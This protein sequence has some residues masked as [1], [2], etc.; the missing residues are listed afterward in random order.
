MTHNDHIH[1]IKEA[2]TLDEAFEVVEDYGQKRG[3]P[4]YMF[5]QI[6][7]HDSPSIFK[8]N[9]VQTN[10][11]DEWV[12]SYKENLYFYID[13]VAKAMVNN[14]MPFF[15]SEHIQ[16]NQDALNDDV[17]TMMAHA[18]Q[19]GLVD[20]TGSSYLKNKGNLCT[21]SMAMDK[22]FESYDHQ[23]LAEVYLIGASL[24][25]V[26][27]R[28]FTK[29]DAYEPLTDRE[30]E[31]IN[32]G[33]VGKTDGEIAQICDISINTVRYHWKNIF[34]KLQSFSR[35]F[36]IVRAMN[37]GYI[38]PYIFEMTTESGSIERYKKNVS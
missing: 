1:A 20:G 29:Y 21:F 32:M 4:L 3:L 23:L 8:V 15:W 31:I 2:N 26:H 6:G 11:P 9:F 7:T 12:N 28:F 16:K 35:V 19:Y 18:T 10:Y 33:A 22:P 37:L 5:A 38:D 17:M 36:A 24:T 27:H 25:H 30:K 13:P 34:E 14:T